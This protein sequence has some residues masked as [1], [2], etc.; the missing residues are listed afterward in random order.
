MNEDFIEKRSGPERRGDGIKDAALYDLLANIQKTVLDTHTALAEFQ[1]EHVFDNDSPH[2][3]ISARL[4]SHQWRLNRHESFLWVAGVVV[5]GII[6]GAVWLAEWVGFEG[7]GA[8]V[9]GAG[10]AQ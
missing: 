10:V 3:L 5:M 7:V 9:R 4:N 1:H 2:A 6:G 8:A